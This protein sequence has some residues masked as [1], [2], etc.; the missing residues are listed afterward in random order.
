[1]NDQFLGRG[2][3]L[4]Q[5]TCAVMAAFVLAIAVGAAALSSSWA[6]TATGAAPGDAAFRAEVARFIDEELR[7]FPERATYA[8][9]HRYDDRVNDL[10]RSGIDTVV[11]HAKRWHKTFGAV[12]ARLLCAANEADRQWL[13]ARLDGYLLWNEQVRSYESDPSMYF[14]TSGV[15]SLVIRDFAP[16]EKRMQLV[17]ARAKASLRNLEAARTNLK[18][19]RAAKI[20]VEIALTELNGS[21]GF[22]RAELPKLFDPI[23][24]GPAKRAFLDANRA[25]VSATEGYARWLREDLLTN[26]SGDY[27]IGADAY[28]RMLLDADMV[29]IPLETLEEVGAH[30]FERLQKGFRQIAARIDPEKSPAEVMDAVTRDHPPADQVI[31]VITAGLASLRDFVRAKQIATIPSDV[32]PIVSETPPFRRAT[33]FASMNTPGPFEKATEA[34]YNVTLPDASWPVERQRQL[35]RL[36]APPTISDTSVHEAYPGHYVQFLNNRLN[37]DL[38]RALY[39]SG[40]NAEGWGLYCEE[41]M[42]DEGLHGDDPRYRL[43]QLQMALM[44]SVRYLAGLGMHTHG[45]TVDEA[46]TMFE[47]K[48]YMTPN[49]ARMEALRGTQDPGYLRYQLGKLMILKLREDVRARQGASFKLGKFHDEFLRQGALPIKLIRRAMLGTDGP[50]L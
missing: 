11:A 14:P 2:G 18:P 5:R 46:A 37:P 35:L 17:T 26:T 28:R 21:L 4:A 39:S 48:A 16:L 50:L 3:S 19:E 36:Y 42:L 20:S 45:M 32:L 33:T 43:V 6:E 34:Y 47:K 29:D 27:A 31:A 10:T 9:D 38:V 49:N 44:R 41:M 22:L 25:L 13:L 7:L 30:E 12:D 23:A 1:M 8:G 24:D 15:Y 40:A